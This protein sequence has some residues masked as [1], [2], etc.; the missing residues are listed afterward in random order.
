MGKF[1]IMLNVIK[2]WIKPL[3]VAIVVAIVGYTIWLFT[4]VPGQLTLNKIT[5]MYTPPPVEH[6]IVVYNEGIKVA[7]YTGKYS[8]EHFDD[9]IVLVNHDD[10]SN[11]DIYGD[12]AV[13][14]DTEEKE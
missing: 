5:G 11:I 3:L 10:N 1:D 12:S 8:I 7:E 6:T 9:H 4:T 13:I 2:R 14:L